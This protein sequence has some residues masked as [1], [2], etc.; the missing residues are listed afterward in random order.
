MN[1]FVIG[2]VPSRYHYEPTVAG[3]NGLIG[4]P[5]LNIYAI[6]RTGDNGKAVF[7]VEKAQETATD[8]LKH[9]VERFSL[10]Y[11]RTGDNVSLLMVVL[12]EHLIEA[13]R[14]SGME[15]NVGDKLFFV[16]KYFQFFGPDN[17]ITKS[18]F[19]GEVKNLDVTFLD[20]MDVINKTPEPKTYGVGE[21]AVKSRDEVLEASELGTSITN[22]DLN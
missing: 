14:E 3:F 4:F 9:G 6:K 17:D 13:T 5:N 11:Q 20:I 7:V 21:V 15:V 16:N 8:V 22:N 19:S 1:L 12:P 10:V 18:L 2:F